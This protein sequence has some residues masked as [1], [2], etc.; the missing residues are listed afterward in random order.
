MVP[1]N[2][3][4]LKLDLV[5]DRI[6]ALLILLQEDLSSL[7]F[8]E[9]EDYRNSIRLLLD[10]ELDEEKFWP[11]CL[12]YPFREAGRSGNLAYLVVNRHQVGIKQQDGTVL[13]LCGPFDFYIAMFRASVGETSIAW[14]IGEMEISINRPEMAHF[15]RITVKGREIDYFFEFSVE[16]ARRKMEEVLPKYGHLVVKRMVR[17]SCHILVSSTWAPERLNSIHHI[18]YKGE[19]DL[20]TSLA[21]HVSDFLASTAV[22]E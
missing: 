12:I 20:E 4:A 7:T 11:A 14:K 21:S 1:S 3:N 18:Y 2:V 22:W 5:V 15:L 8:Q 17:K 9:R 10:Q 6:R 16:D 19:K 13:K